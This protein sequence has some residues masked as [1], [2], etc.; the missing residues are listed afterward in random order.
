MNH[1]SLKTFLNFI[2]LLLLLG[3]IAAVAMWALWQTQTTQINDFGEKVAKHYTWQYQSD[4]NAAIN[5]LD[6][7]G[8]SDLD[9]LRAFLNSLENVRKSDRLDPLKRRALRR[10]IDELRIREENREALSWTER[11]LALD[12]RDVAGLVTHAELLTSLPD[13]RAEGLQ[14]FAAL[15]H[16]LP[17]LE[18]VS[19]PYVTALV[20][21]ASEPGDLA[22]AYSIFD[23]LANSYINIQ[24]ELA[25]L[26]W[27]VLWDTGKSFNGKQK[28]I[29]LPS[30][31]QESLISFTFEIEPGVKRLRI[32]PPIKLKARYS[33]MQINLLSTSPTISADIVDLNLKVNQLEL[34][35]DVIIAQGSGDPYFYFETPEGYAADKKSRWRFDVVASKRFPEALSPLLTAD[36]AKEILADLKAK[37]DSSAMLRYLRLYESQHG[38]LDASLRSWTTAPA[39]GTP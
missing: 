9:P 29:I 20:N 16:K 34:E 35:E 18:I 11:W 12:E 8:T 26:K 31:D 25:E 1:S 23:P 3:V 6:D 24:S 28:Q 36:A 2:R 7:E 17:E 4:Y 33:D 13:R 15:H 21:T 19:S 10:M 27:E 14:A 30:V 38:K 39:G 22:T 5:N 32:D 37:G